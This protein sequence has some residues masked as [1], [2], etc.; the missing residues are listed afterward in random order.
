MDVTVKD[1]FDVFESCK[2]LPVRH[3][4]FKNVGLP[5]DEMKR[6]VRAMKDAGKTPY[7]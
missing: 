1:A 5:K 3:W 4:G 7:L 2:D 6:V